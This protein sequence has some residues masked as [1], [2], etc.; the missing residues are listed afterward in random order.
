LVVVVVVVE[1]VVSFFHCV[2]IHS[3]KTLISWLFQF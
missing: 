1:I 2:L 3:L